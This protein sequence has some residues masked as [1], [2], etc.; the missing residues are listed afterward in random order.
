MNSGEA[1]VKDP[2]ADPSRDEVEAFFAQYTFDVRYEPGDHP[3]M[4]WLIERALASFVRSRRTPH[5]GGKTNMSSRE[6][7]QA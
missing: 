2:L 7:N 3:R 4:M 6:A 5:N 1:K